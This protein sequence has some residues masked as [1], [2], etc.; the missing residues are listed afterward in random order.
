[1][2]ERSA[3]LGISRRTYDTTMERTAKRWCL[4]RKLKVTCQTCPCLE[5]SNPRS[6]FPTDMIFGC[7][8]RLI[9][10]F[11]LW[12]LPFHQCSLC[13]EID[14]NW[15]HFSKFSL[16]RLLFE[17]PYV[18]PP[19]ARQSRAPAFRCFDV[20]VWEQRL[21]R[22]R[23]GTAGAGAG[24]HGALRKDL[25]LGRRFDKEMADV[26]WVPSTHGWE[27]PKLN[28]H[29]GDTMWYITVYTWFSRTIFGQK[30]VE[31]HWNTWYS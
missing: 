29:L 27:I 24:E 23:G 20:G 14:H 22:C 19:R 7:S 21:Q 3:D 5:T 1:M 13:P 9:W 28:G 17:Q 16:H 25:L 12:V 10:H 30:W 15:V 6:S 31:V 8:S 2:H 11:F 4:Q 26:Y 18:G